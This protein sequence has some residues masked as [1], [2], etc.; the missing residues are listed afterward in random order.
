MPDWNRQSAA[1]LPLE[2]MD[3]HV[4]Q[5][6]V[7]V[8]GGVSRERISHSLEQALRFVELPGEAEGRLYC[9]RR[10]QVSEIDLRARQ[11]DWTE[12]IQ[13]RLD[14]MGAIAVPGFG[15]GAEQADAVYFDNLQQA[16][17]TFLRLEVRRAETLPWFAESMLGV[18]PSAPRPARVMALLE[19]TE[20]PPVPP[21]AGPGIVLAALGDSDPTALLEAL[22]ETFVR[23]WL[24]NWEISPHHAPWAAP[25][26]FKMHLRA[27]VERAAEHFGWHAPQTLWLAL[28]C[29]RAAAPAAA[30]GIALERARATV[31]AMETAGREEH[32]ETQSTSTREVAR[33]LVFEPDPAVKLPMPASRKDLV[34]NKAA[35]EIGAHPGVADSAM[36]ARVH[37]PLVT[38]P[39]SQ[40]SAIAG[41][42]TSAGGLYFLLAVLRHLGIA[43]I[44]QRFPRL[45]EAAFADHILRQLALSCGV[46]ENDAA[47]AF[48][49]A[50]PVGFDP[51]GAVEFEALWPANATPRFQV[52]KGS[53]SWLL[54][55]WSLAV[56]RWCWRTGRLTLADI[57]LRP[58]RV[59][60]AGPELDI[61]MPLD[62]ADVRIRRLGLDIDPAWVPWLGPSGSIVRFH[63]RDREG[64]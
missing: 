44:I 15:P 60:I 38:E 63:Y 46:A 33:R 61:V 56:R 9:F 24:R 58:G 7:R 19:R 51:P 42:A 29:V 5:S 48:L 41:E 30:R 39:E 55:L 47:L 12:A 11:S 36:I 54:R 22:P 62:S 32:I 52:G 3:R 13:H 16:L 23:A 59:V 14:A 10:V 37:P 21:G 4:R 1:T 25:L 8:Q 45:Q 20:R 35:F 34:A 57:V 26:E 64:V 43:E 28:E 50:A 49:S 2:R 31:S 27:A 17:A 6:I 40:R 53:P 18:E